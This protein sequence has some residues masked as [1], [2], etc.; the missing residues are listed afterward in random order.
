MIFEIWE[1]ILEQERLS[2]KKSIGR[3]CKILDRS[4]IN[5]SRHFLKSW[6]AGGQYS[7][8][9]EGK[10]WDQL[11]AKKKKKEDD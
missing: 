1:L 4:D 2:S 10:T 5:T 9:W 7:G 3:V 6:A 11:G 8:P